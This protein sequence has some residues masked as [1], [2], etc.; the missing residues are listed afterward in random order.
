MDINVTGEFLL[1]I[2][3]NIL[4]LGVY[5]GSLKTAMSFFKEGLKRL[6]EKQDKHNA[7][8][9]RTFHLEESVKALHQRVTEM[10][11]DIK[12]L[13]DRYDEK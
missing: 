10:R 6:E 5:I 7:V 2:I 1:V 12:E 3:I 8:I 4:S 9:E 13:R 11:Q